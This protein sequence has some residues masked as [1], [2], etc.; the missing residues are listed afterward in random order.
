MVDIFV[1]REK[2]LNFIENIKNSNFFLIVLGRRR[3]GKTA[4]LLKALPEAAY[5][6]IWPNKS[7]TWIIEEI[8]RDLRI[9]LFKNFSDII[10]YLL[11]HNKI[12]IL[13]EFQNLLKIDKS[14][15]GELQRIIDERMIKGKPLRLVACGSSNSM[16]NKIL[17][18]VASPLYGRRTH[19]L[20]LTHLP[21]SA[22]YNWMNVSMEEVV[23][24][25]SVFEG[26]PYYYKLINAKKSPEENI[27]NLVLS[28]NSLLREEGKVV[29]SVEFGEESKVYYTILSLIAEGK[30]KLH[31]ISS[32]FDNKPYV[33]SKYLDK[34]RSD[35]NLVKRFTPILSDP[36][37][38]KE[39]IYTIND[40]FLLFWFKFVER[41]R[42]LIE[43]ER[44]EEIERYFYDNFNNYVG[45]LFEKFAL[46][47]IKEKYSSFTKIGKQF[48]KIP[49]T[50]DTYEIDLLAVNEQTK[51]LLAVEVKW[52]DLK[53]RD[54]RKIIDELHEKLPYVQWH[55]EK[56]KE[57]LGIFAKKVDKRARDWLISEGYKV[58][59]L[60]DVEKLVK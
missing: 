32:F 29:L 55:N 30:N 11:D 17:Y 49:K 6:F 26:V 7:V 5:I 20:R 21:I 9:P 43:Q 44:Y 42:P 40:N 59:D 14:I 39:G 51:E 47:I 3:I 45:R 56:R 33:V 24:L 18:D 12:V 52:Q 50:K 35:F 36:R 23:K 10:E 27:V 54:V 4:L 15:Y 48:G 57:T 13:D 37:K 28:E 2:E 38:S 19:E 22:I 46:N 53:L 60:K 1:D 41:N 8:S 31:Q 58:W 16:I 34:L 25:W